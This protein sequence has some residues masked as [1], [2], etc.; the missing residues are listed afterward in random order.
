MNELTACT[1][2]KS[3]PDCDKLAGEMKDNENYETVVTNAWQNDEMSATSLLVALHNLVSKPIDPKWQTETK[4][5]SSHRVHC[6]KQ[7]LSFLASSGLQGDLGQA[8]AKLVKAAKAHSIFAQLPGF[9][10]SV[11]D[12]DPD[13]HA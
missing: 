8:P 13:C 6:L 2:N 12:A 7:E 3:L 10:H 1:A 5:G 9:A 4:K 11:D